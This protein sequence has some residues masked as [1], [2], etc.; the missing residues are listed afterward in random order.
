M[1]CRISDAVS[2][3]MDVKFDTFWERGVEFPPFKVD[4]NFVVE[5]LP[6]VLDSAVETR[7]SRSFCLTEPVAAQLGQLFLSAKS[8]RT[9]HAF[10][11]HSGL[12][13]V[14]ALVLA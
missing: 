6:A 2:A 8:A 13:A 7:I 14:N 10:A 4:N 11:P 9:K 12:Q 1:A 5:F 3:G